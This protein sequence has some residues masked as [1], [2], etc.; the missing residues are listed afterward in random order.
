MRSLGD[1]RMRQGRITD[2][3]RWWRI[4]DARGEPTRKPPPPPRPKPDHPLLRATRESGIPTMSMLPSST[5]PAGT[6]K[7]PGYATCFARN[8]MATGGHDMCRWRPGTLVPPS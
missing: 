1:H 4:S 6:R 7:P 3:Q 2:V 8:P 5:T